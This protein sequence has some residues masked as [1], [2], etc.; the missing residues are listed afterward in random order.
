MPTPSPPPPPSPP[1]HP[2]VET[3]ITECQ[4][5]AHEITQIGAAEAAAILAKGEAE[6]KVRRA[7][8]KNRAPF[9]IITFQYCVLLLLQRSGGRSHPIPRAS[10]L[11]LQHLFYQQ[12][13]RGEND[14]EVFNTFAGVFFS[15]GYKKR[16]VP[17]LSQCE[18]RVVNLSSVFFEGFKK[19]QRFPKIGTRSPVFR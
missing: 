12:A 19:F 13:T 7:E 16:R 17:L 10:L 9:A 18:F 15:K 11:Q 2:T 3:P 8:I 1:Q 4:A 5:K 6:A 14:Q